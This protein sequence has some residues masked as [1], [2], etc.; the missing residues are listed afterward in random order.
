MDKTLDTPP[1]AVLIG[2]WEHS[3]TLTDSSVHFRN[4]GKD[5]S[6][7]PWHLGTRLSDMACCCSCSFSRRRLG[8]RLKSWKG[9]SDRFLSG[10]ETFK[11]LLVSIG[12][13]FGWR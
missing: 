12:T 11:G 1:S 8:Q 10:A 2:K 9:V 5:Q 4:L 13:Y 6:N 3:I 7:Y